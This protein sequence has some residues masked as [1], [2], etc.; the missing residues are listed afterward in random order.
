MRI[1]VI[2]IMLT[3]PFGIAFGQ[4]EPDQ[5][6]KPL[7]VC[8]VFSDLKRHS[9]DNCDRPV[10]TNGYHWENRIDLP[11]SDAAEKASGVPLDEGVLSDKLA[12]I[13]KTTELHCSD[14]PVLLTSGGV[15]MRKFKDRWAV[16][17]G[18]LEIRSGLRPPTGRHL[19]SSFRLG[20][21]FGHLGRA[22]VRLVVFTETRFIEIGTCDGKR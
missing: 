1:A 8:E 14:W 15:E 22:P 16:A 4:A 13:Q 9:E 19:T 5:P 17:Y 10:V 7:T 18:S 3:F 21:G 6:I 2:A 12:L 11:F 20:N